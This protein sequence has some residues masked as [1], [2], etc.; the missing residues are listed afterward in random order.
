[1]K[2]KQ[3]EERIHSL[4]EQHQQKDKTIATLRNSI[5]VKEREL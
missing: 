3:L 4:E 1:M 5:E 2:L